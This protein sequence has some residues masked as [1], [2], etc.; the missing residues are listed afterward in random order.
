MSGR[1]EEFVSEREQ[2][3]EMN[4]SLGGQMILMAKSTDTEREGAKQTKQKTKARCVRR[5]H[6][7]IPRHGLKQAGDAS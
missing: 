4:E 3:L 6:H 7:A 5:E 2:I 1:L